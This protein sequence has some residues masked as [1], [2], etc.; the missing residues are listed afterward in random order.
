MSSVEKLTRC[1][2]QCPFYF[3]ANVPLCDF[4]P[5]NGSTE[6]WLGSHSH[7]SSADQIIATEEDAIGK[8]RVGDPHC[9][10]K[11]DIM[12]A[13][14]Q[15]RPPIQAVC[16]KGDIMIRDLRL[17]HA[18]MPNESSSYRV[19]IAIGYQAPWFPNHRQRNNLP[20]SQCNFFTSANGQPVE[21][22]ANFGSDEE[23]E[24]AR[25]GDTF[26]FR[27]SI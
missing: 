18:G 15:V 13:R 22:R 10:I 8:Q 21:M 12:E 16:K 17:W 26:D 9:F 11:P 3:I 7:T 23:A 5:S 24:S 20:L 4:D 14:R 6:F 25:H 27:P 19:M 1:D 2:I